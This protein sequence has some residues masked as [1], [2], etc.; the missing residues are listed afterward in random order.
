MAA[1]APPVHPSR[2][3]LIPPRSA[4]SG[5]GVTGGGSAVIFGPGGFFF[6][7]RSSRSVTSAVMAGPFDVPACSV[8]RMSI[9]PKHKSYMRGSEGPSAHGSERIR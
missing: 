7:R 9:G 3:L 1:R 4:L 5:G 6:F 8:C 2:E